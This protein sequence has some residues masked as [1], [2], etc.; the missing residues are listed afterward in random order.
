[1][2]S[3]VVMRYRYPYSRRVNVVLNWKF[4]I[5]AEDD[6]DRYYD[7]FCSHTGRLLNPGDPW[8]DNGDGVPSKEDVAVLLA[9]FDREH[10]AV[11]VHCDTTHA[12]NANHK[13]EEPR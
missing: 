13:C 1:M 11:C 7:M 2:P 3:A 4:G 12:I 9:D 6:P 5:R 8:H 10:L